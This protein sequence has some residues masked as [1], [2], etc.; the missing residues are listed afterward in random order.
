MVQEA[1]LLTVFCQRCKLKRWSLYLALND[2]LLLEHLLLLLELSGSYLSI[3]LK[4]TFSFIRALE[5]LAAYTFAVLVTRNS[6]LEAL[7]VLFE[8]FRLLAVT[9]L[10]MAVLTT[11][12]DKV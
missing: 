10:S 7:T 5:I 2:L 3:V 12:T 11:L 6:S 4:N 1:V 9:A 8:A